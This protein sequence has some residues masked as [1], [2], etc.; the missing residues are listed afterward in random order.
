MNG[1]DKEKL[2]ELVL[3][4]NVDSEIDEDGK[5][6]LL[7]NKGLANHNANLSETNSRIDKSSIAK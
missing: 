2:I 1:I 3:N 7:E 6:E 5:N 4:V